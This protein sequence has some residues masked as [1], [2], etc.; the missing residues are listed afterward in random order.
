MSMY[1]NT[2]YSASIAFSCSFIVS[3]DEKF[4]EMAKC[5]LIKVLVKWF[6]LTLGLNA[7]CQSVKSSI[8]FVPFDDKCRGG[9]HE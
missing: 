3:E 8:H 9:A 2:M 7:M 1:T 6:M 4:P 5:N